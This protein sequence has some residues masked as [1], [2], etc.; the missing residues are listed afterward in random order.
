[1]PVLLLLVAVL[2][3][4]AGGAERE[5]VSSSDA[6]A[7]LLCL[8]EPGHPPDA[9]A[10]GAVECVVVPL[11][12]GGCSA[13]SPAPEP[14]SAM[15]SALSAE[16]WSEWLGACH[17]EGVC[18][19]GGLDLLR[20]GTGPAGQGLQAKH[21]E[22]FEI[23]IDG[24]CADTADPGW[25]ASVWSSEVRRVWAAL[26]DDVATRLPD[27]D[28]LVVRCEYSLTAMRG[29]SDVARAAYITR[30]GRDPVDLVPMSSRPRTPADVAAWYAWRE[31][32]VT[33]ALRMFASTYGAAQP[34]DL[35]I[36]WASPQYYRDD[37]A[38]RARACSPWATWA[39]E[40]TVDGVLIEGPWLHTQAAGEGQV[41]PRLYA[42]SVA[43]LSRMAPVPMFVPTIPTQFAGEPVDLA[44]ELLQLRS[45]GPV[46]AL[47]IF[48]RDPSDLDRALTALRAFEPD[49]LPE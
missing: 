41:G 38:S 45:E 29:F 10:L 19:L 9:A 25:Y 40:G 3:G 39:S 37:P 35:L 4:Q 23:G 13:L 21:P 5:P 27:L 15:A 32:S 49:T 20:W 34:D 43:L 48:V 46:P 26:A 47:G 16:Q 36:A 17:E 42:S 24:A 33:D 7:T 8:A 28:G 44:A 6:P 30:A 1:V 11:I 12:Q 14:F 2:A 18:V 22:W 31:D